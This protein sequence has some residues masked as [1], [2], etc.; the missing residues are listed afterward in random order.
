MVKQ[1]IINDATFD[2]GRSVG[3]SK[4]QGPTLREPKIRVA[5]PIYSRGM[6]VR[7]PADRERHRQ[8][9]RRLWEEE[10]LSSSA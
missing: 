4:L 3:Y 9:R 1:Q 2:R 8:P 6:A 7:L 5:A 10:E